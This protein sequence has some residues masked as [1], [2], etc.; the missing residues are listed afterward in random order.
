[1]SS[2]LTIYELLYLVLGSGAL[3]G[4]ITTFLTW[5]HEG[6]VRE[7]NI[8]LE[9]KKTAAANA[10]QD[11]RT[12][13]KNELEDKRAALALD[14]ERRK[15]A[16]KYYLP[17]YGHIV[18]VS[19]YAKAYNRCPPN[20]SEMV[21]YYEKNNSCFKRLPEKNILD[22]FKKS[23]EKFCNYYIEQKGEGNE[24][25]L[26][27]ELERNIVSFW[28]D[29]KSFDDDSKKMKDDEK[30]KKFDTIVEDVTEIMEKLFGLRNE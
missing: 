11:R 15:L 9:A 23:Y 7:R 22:L 17:L 13:A 26:T 25:Y 2:T 27:N 18:V 5:Y 28:R 20:G 3:L 1:M 19:E 4:L 16:E 8:E 12:E 6:Q 14:R 30:I 24:I 29:A 21:F 10:L